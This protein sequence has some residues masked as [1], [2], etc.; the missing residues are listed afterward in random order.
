MK[1]LL[2]TLLM[3]ALLMTC[4]A[5]AESADYTGI[6]Y[7]NEIQ[8]GE[9]SMAPGTL[10][11]DMTMELSEDG[12]GMLTASV[13]DGEQ[14]CTWELDGE[15]LNVTVDGDVMTLSLQEDGSL[16][17]E[18]GGMGMV[19]GREKIEAE[20]Y[21]PGEPVATATEADYAGSWKAA[22][23]QAE[24][25]YIDVSLFGMDLTADIE[26]T[27]MTLN[28]MYVLEN[29]TVETNLTDGA[30]VGKDGIV[31]MYSGITAQLLDDDTIIISFAFE[32]SDPVTLILVRAE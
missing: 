23:M 14:E 31:D 7:L 2:A 30:L 11:M 25:N 13:E 12:K 28:G 6:W 29:V 19:F 3:A 20:A 21:T 24:G 15:T 1:R 27:T 10:G 32:D 5:I 9:A 16:A 4:V 18:Q 26:G 22:W 8:I 17:G